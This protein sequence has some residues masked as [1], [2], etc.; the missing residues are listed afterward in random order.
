MG[1]D[2]GVLAAWV[3]YKEPLPLTFAL[4]HGPHNPTPIDNAGVKSI[5][6]WYHNILQYGLK[7]H[8]PRKLTITVDTEIYNGLLRVVGRGRI[9]GFLNDLARPHVVGQDLSAG[10]AAM[11]ADE[12]REAEAAAWS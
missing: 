1:V 3:Y 11:A 2:L 6:A 12:A 10:Y 4:G 5:G 8:M 9:S 7:A